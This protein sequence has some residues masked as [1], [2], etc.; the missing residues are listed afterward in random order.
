M[1]PTNADLRQFILNFFSDEE[2]ETLCFDYFPEVR[3]DFTIGMIKNSKVMLLIDYCQVR[4][5]GDDLY[6]AL[7]RERPSAWRE[8]FGAAPV[9][10]FRRNVSTPRPNEQGTMTHAC[11]LYTSPSP[12]DRTRY[13]MPSSA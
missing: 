11:L 4:G 5:R 7:E 1:T 9:E 12:R 2:L 6:G 3:Q 8:K 13:R 10:T